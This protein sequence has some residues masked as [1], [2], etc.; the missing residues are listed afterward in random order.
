MTTQSQEYKP[1][2]KGNLPPQF[3]PRLVLILKITN[4]FEKVKRKQKYTSL[5]AVGDTQISPKY[6]F[7]F[8]LLEASCVLCS[9]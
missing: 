8:K 7:F 5:A 3:Q 1:S 6:A 2:Q 9:L 4:C